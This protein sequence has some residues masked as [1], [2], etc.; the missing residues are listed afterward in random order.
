MVSSNGELQRQVSVDKLQELLKVCGENDSLD[1]KQYF[2]INSQR[3]RAELVR[4]ILAF[5]NTADGGHMVFG[6]IDQPFNP[7]GLERNIRIDTTLIY[8][9]VSK[10]IAD[11]R[12]MVAVHEIQWPDWS[13]KRRFA[14]LYISEYSGIAMPSYDVA[15]ADELKQKTVI[16]VKP[17]DIM[18][19]RGAQSIRAEKTDIQQL[20]YRKRA[21]LESIGDQRCL[22]EDNLPAREQIALDFIGRTQELAEIWGW[23]NDFT[24]RKWLLAGDGGKGKT[25]L[26]YEFA[27]QVKQTSPE[28]FHYIFWLSAKRRQFVEGI[29][30]SIETPD[31]WDLSS[32][33]DAIVK[34]YGFT[35]Y[36]DLPIYEKRERTKE[37]L[38]ELPALIIADDIDSLDPQNE[39]ALE[40][41]TADLASTPSK[42]LLTSR[43]VPFGM[44]AAKTQIS[45][46]N[47]RDAEQFISSRV[48]IYNL[49]KKIF[50]PKIVSDIL[51]VTEGSPLYIEDLLRLCNILPVREAILE[52]KK[53]GGDNAREY[54]LKREF[55]RLSPSAKVIVLACCIPERPV[56]LTEI[57]AITG[58]SRDNIIGEMPAIQS[59]FLVS[60][61]RLIE[62]VERFDVNINIRTLV[63]SIFEQ[64]DTLWRLKEA[65]KNILGE[66]NNRAQGEIVS[67]IRQA[68]ALE[69][70]E[71]YEDAKKILQSALQ[72]YPNNP[73]LTAQLGVTYLHWQPIRRLADAREQFKRA[74]ELKCREF[75]MYRTWTK[76]ELEQHEW[77]AAIEAAEAGIKN[78]NASNNELYYLAGF[79]HSRLAQDLKNSWLTERARKEFLA[80]DKMLRQALKDPEELANYDER[81]LNSRIFRALVINYEQFEHITDMHRFLDRW[82]REHPDDPYAISEGERL[83]AKYPHRPASKNQ[84]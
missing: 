82:Q 81:Q 14:I 60:H 23:F 5:A 17:N 54:S 44:N 36:L 41:L 7:I 49:D 25:A 27:T 28:N 40:F 10:Y 21:F 58:R 35:E 9:A 59:L 77:S 65:Y 33:L 2:S 78:T 55:D 84:I 39:D 38:T 19:R 24:R 1:F 68:R 67:Y 6:V 11:I 74:A 57:Q 45:G 63:L 53:R 61:P 46:L 62:G 70:L 73:Q 13:T 72:V 80:A 29:I 66:Q 71:R 56:S 34:E 64:S 30:Q 18:V 79:A 83:T 42:V 3:E 16:V 76:T 20:M 75:W 43:R 48:E 15:Y 32:L 37:L 12:L 26:A 8:Q 4:D 50:N 69:R 22:L 52:W 51:Q 47:Q 31:F